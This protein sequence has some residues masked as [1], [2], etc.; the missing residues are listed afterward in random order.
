MSQEARNQSKGLPHSHDCFVCGERNPAGFRGK[1]ELDE[2]QHVL[3]RFRGHRTMQGFGTIM[4]GGLQATV[5]DET[6]GWATAISCKRM[7]VLA[8][9]NVRYMKRTPLETDLVVEAWTTSVSS[10]LVKAEGVIRDE[11]GTIYTKAVGKFTALSLEETLFVDDHLIYH[12]GDVHIFEGAT[13]SKE[14]RKKPI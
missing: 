1:F 11:A 6:M 14:V 5:L 8:E 12:E 7:T 10:R 3:F 2:N 13:D 4:H 9:I